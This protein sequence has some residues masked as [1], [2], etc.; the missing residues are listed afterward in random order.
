M[1]SDE[2]GVGWW[3]LA[4]DGAGVVD[5][6]PDNV[7][8][9]VFA[10]GEDDAALGAFGEA[11]GE[12]DVVFGLRPTRHEEHVDR[13]VFFGTELSFTQSDLLGARVGRV[14]Q[15][16]LFRFEV[17]GGQAI[18]DE[19]DLLIGRVLRGQQA[20]GLLQGMLDVREVWR[21]AAFADIGVAHIRAEPDDRVADGWDL[22][23]EF[24][25]LADVAGLG[26]AVH[27]DE[28]Q[29]I[30]GVFLADQAV[31]SEGHAFAV[32]ILAA[33]AHGAGHIHDDAGGALGVVAGEVDFDVVLVQPHPG[34]AFCGGFLV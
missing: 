21:D 30:A 32:D 24:S 6:V 16:K 18:G 8:V 19:D 7:A 9:E 29:V 10:S 27:L 3:C 20:A 22:G 14:E 5:V 1:V 25:D 13:D 2:W 4:D 34:E 17:R 28:L 33:G 31:E 12:G 15:V 26:E 11:I 23:H